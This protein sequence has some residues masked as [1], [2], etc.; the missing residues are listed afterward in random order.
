[1]YTENNLDS[2]KVIHVPIESKIPQLV[3]TYNLDNYKK[4]GA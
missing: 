2:I 4:K 1:M 3:Y